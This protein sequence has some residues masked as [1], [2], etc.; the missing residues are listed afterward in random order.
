MDLKTA[1]S[2]VRGA[3][4]ARNG[5]LGLY[6]VAVGA[7]GFGAGEVSGGAALVQ[8]RA[9]GNSPEQRQG[10]LVDDPEPDWVLGALG[11]AVDG[12]S[13]ATFQARANPGCDRCPTRRS[14]PLH[15]TGQQVTR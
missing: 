10:P 6:Q 4:L 3:D 13:A 11:E 9:P 7:G 14:C 15:A 5:Q 1:S 8:L 12:M 2:K